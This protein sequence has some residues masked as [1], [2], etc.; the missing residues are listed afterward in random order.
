MLGVQ[1]KDALARIILALAGSAWPAVVLALRLRL[2]AAH[3]GQRGVDQIEEQARLA[4]VDDEHADARKRTSRSSRSLARIASARSCKLAT[5]HSRL[6][7]SAEPAAPSA[8]S[9]ASRAR[10]VSARSLFELIGSPIPASP[11]APPGAAASGGDEPQA[12]RRHHRLNAVAGAYLPHRALKME[13]HG[14]L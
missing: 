8:A 11:S 4:H 14:M 6:G 10:C 9:T 5:R 3:V 12:D 1:T 7:R 13:L 2:Q